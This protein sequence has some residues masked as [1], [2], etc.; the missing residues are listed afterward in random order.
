MRRAKTTANGGQ[1]FA[2][3]RPFPCE[4]ADGVPISYPPPTVGNQKAAEMLLRLIN[5]EV[6]IHLQGANFQVPLLFQEV[7][8]YILL[9]MNVNP[10]H[11]FQ[12]ETE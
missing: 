12:L 2:T 8:L 10:K 9:P 5:M 3:K 11:N 1:T 4:T 6:E 7:Y